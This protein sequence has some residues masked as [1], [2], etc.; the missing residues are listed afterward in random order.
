MDMGS[1]ERPG[2]SPVVM[3]IN[4]L[5]LSN[6]IICILS[7]GYICGTRFSPKFSDSRLEPRGKTAT[8]GYL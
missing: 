5:L 4:R 1:R 2:P 6:E 3:A 7:R 8:P